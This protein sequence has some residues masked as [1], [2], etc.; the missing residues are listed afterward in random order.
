[1]A[2]IDVTLG[3]NNRGALAALDAVQ[4]SVGQL[5]GKFLSLENIVGGLVLGNLITQSFQLAKNNIGLSEANMAA[6]SAAQ[7]MSDNMIKL[8]TAFI[9]I[10]EPINKMISSIEVSKQTIVDFGKVLLSAIEWGALFLGVGLAVKALRVLYEAFVATR[11]VMLATGTGIKQLYTALT[12]PLTRANLLENL[13][14]L[15]GIGSKADAI[16]RAMS[17][18][19]DFLK[20]NFGKLAFAIGAAT[21]ALAKFLGLQ[22]E[23]STGSMG[24]VYGTE[25]VERMYK[26]EELRLETLRNA[27]KENDIAIENYKR[28]NRNALEQLQLQNKIFNKGEDYG[29]LQKTMLD[30]EQRRR[31]VI[32]GLQDRISA[33]TPEQVRFGVGDVL[34]AQIEAYKKLQIAADGAQLGQIKNLQRQRAELDAFNKQLEYNTQMYE[35]QAQRAQTLADILR[36]TRQN[37]GD[38]LFQ[39]EQLTQGPIEQQINQAYE[40][41]RKNTL[42]AQRQFAE[43]FADTGDGMTPER[44]AELQKGLDDIAFAF[45]QIARES[46]SNI[47]ISQQWSTGWQ[48]AINSFRDNA[49]NAADRAREVFNIFTSNTESALENMVRTGKLGFKDLVRSIILDLTSS[50][51]KQ[52]FRNLFLMTGSSG[53]GNFLATIGSWFAGF[54]ANG[55][56]IPPGKAG[57]V[58]EAGPELVSGPANV[59]PL[60]G[61][62]GAPVN[63]YYTYNISAIDSRSVAQ[64]FAEHRRTMLG[65][66]EQARKE[67]PI[68]QR[69]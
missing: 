19:V 51:L 34:R 45:R 42:E 47:L 61:M 52:A 56:F 60:G 63:N 66:T 64:F 38:L 20:N 37:R 40:D 3:I 14:L 15:P 57:I 4:R 62:G 30:M 55:G 18:P 58:G 16:L 69:F 1:M 6:A 50:A 67:L 54:F 36:N 41:M 59:T 35:Q 24:R 27:N 48:S 49:M 31:A 17:I 44:M 23:E 11:A 7:T 33:L 13:K 9:E 28:Q 26:F 8:Q 21:G 65:A 29:E 5:S 22:K 12:T 46:E 43:S 10:I 25:A 32:E 39:R 2:D 53:G 68:R